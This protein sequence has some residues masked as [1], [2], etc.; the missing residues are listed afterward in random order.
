[1]PSEFKAGKEEDAL[2]YVLPLMRQ[3][4]ITHEEE[5]FFLFVVV[6]PICGKVVYE[7]TSL[8]Y[9][10]IPTHTLDLLCRGCNV[11]WR[12]KIKDVFN[13]EGWKLRSINV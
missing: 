5:E 3:R 10:N 8:D 9:D 13:S 12:W 6:C 2:R 1:M 11:I 4:H 7:G